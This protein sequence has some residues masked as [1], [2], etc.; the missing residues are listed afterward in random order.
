MVATRSGP[1]GQWCRS[2]RDR[3]GGGAVVRWVREVAGVG[4]TYPRPSPRPARGHRRGRIKQVGVQESRARWSMPIRPVETIS[5]PSLTGLRCPESS[6]VVAHRCGPPRAGPRRRSGPPSATC[7]S[8]GSGSALPGAR[9]PAGAH[10]GCCAAASAPASRYCKHLG[11]RP[12]GRRGDQV[13]HSGGGRPTHRPATLPIRPSDPWPGAG[14]GRARVRPG[15]CAR[16]L[17]GSAPAQQFAAQPVTW[18]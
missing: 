2:S 7:P 14:I 6:T 17:L 13:R 18:N 16:I 4:G 10:R 11:R 1:R 8:A 5:G 9:A 15:R 3:A 12:A